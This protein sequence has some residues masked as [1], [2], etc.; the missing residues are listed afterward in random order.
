MNQE[1]TGRHVMLSEMHALVAE[2][3]HLWELVGPVA[4]TEH[5]R[6]GRSVTFSTWGTEQSQSVVLRWFSAGWIELVADL[7]IR[8]WDAAQWRGR[9][10][11][12]GDFV[13]L[14]HEDAQLLLRDSSRWR[15]GTDDGSVMLSQSN[16]GSKHTYDDWLSIAEE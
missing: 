1:S 11:R 7:H 3:A 10:V 6:D 12:S 15:S 4:V 2:G 14:T 8:D 5:R 13:T 9:A 16:E